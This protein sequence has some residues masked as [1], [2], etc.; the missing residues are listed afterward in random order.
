M[1]GQ[2]TDGQTAGHNDCN[3]PLKF[4]KGGIKMTGGSLTYHWTNDSLWSLCS[5]PRFGVK[6]NLPK[7]PLCN[8][9][10]EGF[11]LK[12]TCTPLSRSMAK[13]RKGPGRSSHHYL[14][15]AVSPNKAGQ[16]HSHIIKQGTLDLS[17]FV[18]SLSNKWFPSKCP[19]PPTLP[20]M[21]L[22]WCSECGL[23]PNI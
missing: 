3:I 20:P 12:V 14:T 8:C 6:I 17:P 23:E 2:N 4:V 19:S 7:S 10:C 9:F 1:S 16:A 5:T 15:P 22:Q 13:L 21:S 11:K 18:N